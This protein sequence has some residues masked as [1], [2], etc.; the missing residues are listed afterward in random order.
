MKDSDVIFHQSLKDFPCP[1]AL[2]K[3]TPTFGLHRYKQGLRFLP[4]ENEG[5]TLRGDRR[6]LLYKGRRR[7]HRFTILSDKSFEYDCILEREP[8]SNIV[9]LLMEGAEKFD[10]FRQPDFVKNPFL[11]GSYAVYKK[12]TF[13]GEGTGKLC[14]IH[15]PL[16]IDAR[17]RRV[18]GT[19]AV[20]GN[21]LRITIP[22]WWLSGAKYPVV[23]D[24]V[25]GTNTVGSMS[26]VDL[27][28][29]GI[30]TALCFD[31]TMAINRFSVF[32]QLIE[33]FTAYIYAGDNVYGYGADLVRG[34]PILY[35]EN[36]NGDPY[37]KLTNS[38][39][40]VS[41][42]PS[43]GP[44][45]IA[46]PIITNSTIYPG[47]YIYFGVA[48]KRYWYPRFDYGMTCSTIN[49]N[50]N[51]GLPEYAPGVSRRLNLKLS[52]YCENVY[53]DNFIR[54]I[55]QGVKLSDRRIIKADYKRNFAQ[56]VGVNSLLTRYAAFFMKVQEIGK[57]LDSFNLTAVFERSVQEVVN[58]IEV[59]K[60]IA[61]YIVN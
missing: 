54:T 47:T 19:L 32:E 37:M 7:S 5:F 17:G 20:A 48:S 31:S 10:F 45:W 30:A 13:I 12:E 60:H 36:Y 25:F 43:A 50:I 14:H 46:A 21:E 8:E 51:S 61:A 44:G 27:N 26:E 57:G 18:W 55:T 49:W 4:P 22:E 11:K 6:R 58:N 52:M 24:P 34:I 15:R 23:V 28:Y 16:I 1:V 9:S 29:T 2:G 35:S 38:E 39:K 41:L 40:D 33:S 42:V 56:T 53:L 59:F 3:N